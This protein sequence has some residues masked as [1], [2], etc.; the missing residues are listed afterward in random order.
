M[1]ETP[2]DKIGK[3]L[4]KL[5]ADN[6]KV[7]EDIGKGVAITRVSVVDVE[8]F[9]KPDDRPNPTTMMVTTVVKPKTIVDC[10]SYIRHDSVD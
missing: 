6:K 1:K 8:I 3:L 2:N 9:L 5:K 10:V 4:Q 7:V